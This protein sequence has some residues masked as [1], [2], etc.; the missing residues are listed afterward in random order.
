MDI[1]IINLINNCKEF[2]KLEDLIFAFENSNSSL[3]NDLEIDFKSSDRKNK[4]P[5]NKTKTVTFDTVEHWWYSKD[6]LFNGC[7]IYF[8]KLKFKRKQKDKDRKQKDKDKD[9]DSIYEISSIEIF[10]EVNRENQKLELKQ[11]LIIVPTSGDSNTMSNIIKKLKK[12]KIPYERLKGDKGVWKLI[13]CT[14]TAKEF[15]EKI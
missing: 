3:K 12:A 13:K 6:P 7:E 11:Y 1:N 15:F 14:I 10:T 2:E 5:N 9:E 8:S 4:N